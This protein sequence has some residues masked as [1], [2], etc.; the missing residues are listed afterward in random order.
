MTS[1]MKK[2]Q[3]WS[4]NDRD[5]PHG[6]ADS[7]LDSHAASN[8]LVFKESIF[9]NLHLLQAVLE[10]NAIHETWEVSSEFGLDLVTRCKE[11]WSITFSST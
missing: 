10:W 7:A 3:P 9:G 6:I 2:K 4:L 8:G 1:Q 11:C 5:P